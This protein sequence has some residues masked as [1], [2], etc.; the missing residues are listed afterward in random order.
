MMKAREAPS[1][2]WR[3]LNIFG[4]HKHQGDCGSCYIFATLGGIES[5]VKKFKD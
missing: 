4:Y 1:I 3:T 2:D 5:H